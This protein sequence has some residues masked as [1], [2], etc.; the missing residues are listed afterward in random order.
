MARE[1]IDQN[2]KVTPAE[3]EPEPI[4]SQTAGELDS[5]GQ[6]V[7]I[8][9][10]PGSR[11]HLLMGDRHNGGAGTV[12]S[13]AAHGCFVKLDDKGERVGAMWDEITMMT[14]QLVDAG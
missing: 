14:P 7:T 13:V 1:S 4:T 9:V 6:G 8:S 5:D 3:G 12:L 2:S 11:L 10:R